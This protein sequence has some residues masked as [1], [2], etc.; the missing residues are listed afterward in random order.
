MEIISSAGK[1]DT[2]V[3]QKRDKIGDLIKLFEELAADRA[4]ITNLVWQKTSG[5]TRSLHLATYLPNLQKVDLCSGIKEIGTGAFMGCRNLAECNIP[6]GVTTIKASAFAD[7]GLTEAS[8]PDTVSELGDGVFRHAHRLKKL[9]IHEDAPLQR[10]PPQ[11]AAYSGIT[12]FKCP[13]K[14]QKILAYAF[15]A[16]ENLESIT[17]NEGLVQIETA[18]LS[19]TNVRFLRIPSTMTSLLLNLHSFPLQEIELAEGNAVFHCIDGILLNES[20]SILFIPQRH[21]SDTG[22]LAIPCG[23]HSARWDVFASIPEIKRLYL[24]DTFVLPAEC[25]TSVFFGSH[26]EAVEVSPRHTVLA[27]QDGVLYTKDPDGNPDQL[28]FFPSASPIKDYVVPPTVKN[29]AP[30]AFYGA[31][32]DSLIFAGNVSLRRG[33]VRH[34]KIETL[35]FCGDVTRSDRSPGIMHC[36][37][38]TVEFS[39]GFKPSYLICSSKVKLIIVPIVAAADVE[40][41]TAPLDKPRVIIA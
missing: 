8:L 30:C 21:I 15:N 26:L 18:A 13:K 14:L 12:A 4:L 23:I 6:R 3:V 17:L 1:N 5:P 37:I 40:Q 29:V 16:C 33:S 9:T 34:S 27:S 36:T 31:R 39:A 35:R 28:L 7:S 24:P 2:V 32:L 11:F 25:S 19:N 22:Y 10:L 20:K 38:G 41:L